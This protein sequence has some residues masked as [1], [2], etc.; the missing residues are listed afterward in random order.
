[1]EEKENTLT[2]V[3][4]KGNETLCE[5][6]FTFHS[7]TF[8]KDYVVFAVPG[9]EESEEQEVSAASYVEKDGNVGDLHEIET[10]EEWAEV[11]EMLGSFL[12]EECDCDECHCEDCDCED[13]NGEH[14][15]C[16]GECCHHHNK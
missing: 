11:E 9:D 10:D 12:D 1:M 5:I 6:L 16:D 15:C 4:E 8:N 7:E 3:D 14:E 2:L 13:C